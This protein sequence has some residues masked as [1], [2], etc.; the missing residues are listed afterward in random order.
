M[1]QISS[2]P[3]ASELLVRDP[4]V[5]PTE[6]LDSLGP[7]QE[8]ILPEIQMEIQPEFQPEIRTGSSQ[9]SLTVGSNKHAVAS[10]PHLDTDDASRMCSHPFQDSGTSPPSSFCSP[11]QT[12]LLKSESMTETAMRLQDTFQCED[13][14]QQKDAYHLP[15]SQWH[16]HPPAPQCSA[17]LQLSVP[18]PQ[19]HQQPDDTTVS[20]AFDGDNSVAPQQRHT[21]ESHRQTTPASS[22]SFT[23]SLLAPA[24]SLLTPATPPAELTAALLVD[25][26]LAT[27]DAPKKCDLVQSSQQNSTKVLKLSIKKK[28][29]Q[30]LKTNF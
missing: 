12:E 1:Q 26:N 13:P 20:V 6:G 24:C 4:S 8:E 28:Q 2:S 19:Q 30:N 10:P 7:T 16:I 9:G 21:S 17:Q 23:T 5:A 27:L 25:R 3:T 11:T 22:P 15:L 29:K 14:Q 18:V